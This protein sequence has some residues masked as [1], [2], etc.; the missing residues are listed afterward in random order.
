VDDLTCP[1]AGAGIE[2]EYRLW[3]TVF[4]R[5]PVELGFTAVPP[6]A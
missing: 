4:F 6:P 2:F 3:V 5:S 1:T